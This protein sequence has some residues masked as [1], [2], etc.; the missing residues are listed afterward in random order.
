MDCSGREHIPEE[1][2]G[3][4]IAAY[5][6]RLTSSDQVFNLT[7]FALTSPVFV[8]SHLFCITSLDASSFLSANL[9]P[10]PLSGGAQGGRQ[11]VV[12]VGDGHQQAHP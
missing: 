8:L 3:D 9:I 12:L 1:E 11:G 6:K 4:M 5:Y 10:F 7:C 2:R